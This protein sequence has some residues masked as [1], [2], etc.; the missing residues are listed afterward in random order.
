[1]FFYFIFAFNFFLYVYER[2]SFFTT[3]P[4]SMQKKRKE[5]K[6]KENIMTALNLVPVYTPKIHQV[7]TLND[8][9]RSNCG[10]AF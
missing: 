1:M 2:Q 8:A 9:T 6:R 5:K 3:N 7:E 10:N 4:F